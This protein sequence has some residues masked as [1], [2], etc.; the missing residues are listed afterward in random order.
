MRVGVLGGGIQ[1]CCI[2]LELASRGVEVALVEAADAVMSAASR[3][4]EGKIHLGWVYANDPTLRTA[5]LQM[6]GAL[7]FQSLL[8]RWVGPAFDA[9]PVSGGFTYAVHA[10]SLVTPEALAATYFE[11]GR[12]IQRLADEDPHA[13][14]FGM[15]DL[16][17]VER[18]GRDDAGAA[19]YGP[20]V[21]ALFATSEVAVEPDAVADLLVKAV[22]GT[23]GIDVRTGHHVTDVDL[24]SRSASAV[25]GPDQPVT[26][27]GP[28]DHIVNCT[29]SDRLAIDAAA[30]LAPPGPWTF[31][32]KY[33][34]RVPGPAGAVPPTT[35]VLGPFGDVVD[36]RTGDYFLAWYPAGR[37]G[38]STAVSPPRWPTRPDPDEA[39]RITRG[40]VDALSAVAPAVCDLAA[41]APPGST[42]VRGGVIYALG[43]SDV[44]DPASRFHQRSDVG[45]ATASGWYHSVDTGKY[46]TA[47]LFAVRTADR[48]LDHG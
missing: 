26:T 25:R 15:D 47:P 23:D 14:Y 36:Y 48:I 46:T 28:Y 33:F 4:T 42:D 13:G 1:G 24:R 10:E 19:A 37:T 16:H 44:D 41:G 45:P 6:R 18:I 22:E 3:H 27:L 40:T 35:V 7:T 32:M 21:S 17:R 29:W 2:A 38:W 20:A 31:R 5:E 30:G 39:D 12:R 11:I 9:V 8:R 43:A 34:V